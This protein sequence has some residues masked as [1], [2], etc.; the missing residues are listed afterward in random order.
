MNGRGEDPRGEEHEREKIVASFA[1]SL[2]R[3]HARQRRARRCGAVRAQAPS[4]GAHPVITAGTIIRLTY[5]HRRCQAQR[6]RRW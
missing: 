5:G 4:T 6:P 3:S 2:H 1:R